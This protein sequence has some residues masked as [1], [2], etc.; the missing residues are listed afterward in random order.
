MIQCLPPQPLGGHR[1]SN[2]SVSHQSLS[3]INDCFI[4]KQYWMKYFRG[5]VFEMLFV[6]I[7]SFTP[8]SWTLLVYLLCW[9]LE[10]SKVPLYTSDTSPVSCQ[11]PFFIWIKRVFC[12]V[13][14]Y[15]MG[16]KTIISTSGLPELDSTATLTLVRL[17]LIL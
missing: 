15:F 6:T 10:Q 3:L 16:P 8:G 4:F 13:K 2:D 7:L 12:F 5:S 1:E 14:S 9:K 17:F 11:C